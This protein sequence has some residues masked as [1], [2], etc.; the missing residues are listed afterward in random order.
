M[1]EVD[2]LDKDKE[3]AYED[4]LN[5]CELGSAQ[6]SL[7]WRDT[8]YD[9]GKDKPYLIV[10]KENDRIVGALP[11]YYYKSKFGDLLTSI[12]W[13]TISGIVCCR[14]KNFS[15]IYERI[16]D[17]SL[18]LAKELNCVAL[19]I[20]TNPFIDDE[21]YFS[22]Y[23]RPDYSMENFVQYICLNE[24]FDDKG[25]IVHPNYARRSN[26]RRNLDKANLQS[27]VISEEQTEANVKD[28]FK[29]YKK[30]MKEIGAVSLSKR[31]FDSALKNLTFKESGK[32]L[33]AFCNGKIVSGCLFLFNKRIMDVYMMCMD[34]KYRNLR[35]NFLL[36]QYMLEW[37]HRNGISILNW[38]SSPQRGDGV[39][40]WKE[41]WG[42]HEHTFLYLTKIMDDISIWK[43]MDCRELVEAY[44]LH[45]LLPFNL[46]KNAES[47]STSKDVL[48]S[49]MQSINSTVR[50]R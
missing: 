28:C 34:S 14:K 33:F 37:A 27:I 38:M 1:L 8:I 25:K 22:K 20:N 15:D 18:S 3:I 42:S 43:K 39:Y 35:A 29:I 4:F 26:L 40:K 16:L 46:L 11:L 44:N 7:N 2:L 9:L 17:Y 32:F 41:Q 5:E 12:A 13:H 6:F 31:F 30:R 48:T 50:V 36:T 47:K 19:S 24:I 21:R 45:Y 10:A 49:F 23:F